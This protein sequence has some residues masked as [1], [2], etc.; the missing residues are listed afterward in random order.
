MRENLGRTQYSL[1]LGRF[2]LIFKF[3]FYFTGCQV[4]NQIAGFYKFDLEWY[5]WAIG[6]IESVRF[7]KYGV[8]SKIKQSFSGELNSGVG[9]KGGIKGVGIA[10]IKGVG[11]NRGE[12]QFG[13]F[14]QFG[15]SGLTGSTP[16]GFG[17]NFGANGASFSQ[18][19][20]G[21]LTN[22]FSATYTEKKLFQSEPKFVTYTTK[23][24]IV[25]FT[26]KPEYFTYTT[27]PKLVTY[28]T[29]PEIVTYTTKP[30]IVTF[31][32]KPEI[33]TYTTKPKI[34]TYTTKPQIIRY[35]TSGSGTNPQYVAPGVTFNP[36]FQ[37]LVGHK[38][39]GHCKC[40]EN[41]RK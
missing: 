28:T 24:E 1:P 18:E 19:I 41:G 37:Q 26:T 36:S 5:E 34:V 35:E 3:M 8:G 23:P 29:K 33:V 6:L 39:N 12:S 40:L 32:T 27:K 20:K 2:L 11:V 9:I 22:S 7:A 38:H 30:E 13:Q 31:T 25:T 16:G 15:S 17:T 4:G 14:S 21:P 10:G